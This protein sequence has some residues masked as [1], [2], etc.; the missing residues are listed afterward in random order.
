MLWVELLVE[1]QRLRPE[2]RLSMWKTRQK[3]SQIGNGVVEQEISESD[4]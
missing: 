3:E 2:I 1:L 4:I